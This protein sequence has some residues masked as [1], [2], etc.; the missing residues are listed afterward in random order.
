MTIYLLSCPLKAL[1]YSFPF[2]AF[3]ACVLIIVLVTM[4]RTKI[5][6]EYVSTNKQYSRLAYE[7]FYVRADAYMWGMILF[8]M[9]VIL[10]Y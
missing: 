3:L 4:L 7:P 2:Y 8:M 5:I 9:Y 10:T 1:Y 6:L